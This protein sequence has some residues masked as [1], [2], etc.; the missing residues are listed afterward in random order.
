MWRSTIRPWAR[1]SSPKVRSGCERRV[2]AE[3]GLNRTCPSTPISSHEMWLWP[4]TTM[5]AS[6][7]LRRRRAGR[8]GR[9]PLSWTMATLTPARRNT[10]VSGR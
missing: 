6:G 1:T 10:L 2:V 5:S 4:N 8:P 9:W 3:P 7:N